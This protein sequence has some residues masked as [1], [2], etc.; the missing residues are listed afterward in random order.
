MKPTLLLLSFFCF[1]A[2][3]FSQGHLITEIGYDNNYDQTGPFG[4]DSLEYVEIYVPDPQPTDPTSIN[5][6]TYNPSQSNSAIAEVGFVKTLNDAILTWDSGGGVYYVIEFPDSTYFGFPT[7]GINDGEC[8]VALVEIGTPSIV[9][10]FWR[11]ET[12]EDFT[13]ADGPAAGAISDPITT[14]FS[15]QCGS[16]GVLLIQMNSADCTCVSIQQNGFGDWEKGPYTSNVPPLEN[17]SNVPVN[18][19]SFNAEAKGQNAHL[20]WVTAQEF[21]NDYFAI[22]HSTDGRSYNEIGTV[23]GRG[24]YSGESNYDFTTEELSSGQ[25]YFKLKQFDFNGNFEVLPIRTVKINDGTTIELYPSLVTDEITLTN[26]EPGSIYQLFDLQGKLIK[27]DTYTSTINAS[28]L[29]SGKY[30]L[31]INNLGFKFF[32]N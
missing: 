29:V 4:I 2:T 3:L 19:I 24:D 7:A 6:V 8:G 10:Q 31:K 22:L 14:D 27:E 21:S 30:V 5:I 11:Y 9:H 18:L 23:L 1:A 15:R 20:N 16:A 26:V 13:A 25:H 32:K 28:E 17:P 12:C